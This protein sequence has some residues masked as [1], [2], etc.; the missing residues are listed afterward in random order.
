[1]RFSYF[2]TKRKQ[3]RLVA[4][5]Q[6]VLSASLT[7]L[8]NLCCHIA[9]WSPSPSGLFFKRNF[10]YFLYILATFSSILILLLFGYF[11]NRHFDRIA[12]LKSQ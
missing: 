5:M 10:E 11:R 2:S 4:I 7:C 6:M 9:L 1:M 8:A 3:L 12:E